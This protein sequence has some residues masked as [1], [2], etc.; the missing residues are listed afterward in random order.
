MTPRARAPDII[1]THSYAWN[2]NITFLIP[3]ILSKG[4]LLDVWPT[5][6]L[7]AWLKET[8]L[9]RRN[10]CSSISYCMKWA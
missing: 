2:G 3:I 10:S 4:L 9:M 1:V 7:K 5:L 8:K 6:P